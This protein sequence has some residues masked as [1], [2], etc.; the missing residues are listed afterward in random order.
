[1]SASVPDP[2][3]LH[4]KERHLTVD[5]IC[6]AS[7]DNFKFPL[8]CLNLM[9][10]AAVDVDDEEFFYHTDELAFHFATVAERMRGQKG[11]ALEVAELESIA[12]SLVDAWRSLWDEDYVSAETLQ[13][14][15]EYESGKFRE[16]MKREP[17]ADEC[18]MLRG[19]VR[20][21]MSRAAAMY[22]SD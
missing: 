12:S 18:E 14:F 8:Q 17:T 9:L 13:Y 2:L 7:I 1:M 3:D 20:E 11:R 10:D 19:V 21:E 5:E 15:F 22:N 4:M 6:K 16:V